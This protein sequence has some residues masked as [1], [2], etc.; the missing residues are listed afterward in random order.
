MGKKFAILIGPSG[1]G[2]NT[3]CRE[4]V[5]YSHSK[6]SFFKTIQ[7]TTRNMREEEKKQSNTIFNCQKSNYLFI[8]EP[9]YNLLQDNLVGTIKKDIYKFNGFYGT[10]PLFHHTSVNVII[11]AVE[12]LN[13]FLNTYKFDKDDLLR[14]FYINGL[15]SIERD[16]RDSSKENGEILDSLFSLKPNINDFRVI[17]LLSDSRTNAQ[18]IIR[19]FE[20]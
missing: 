9:T 18:N 14:I 10:I 13:D 3:I 17:P 4:L 16:D 15:H 8:D 1:S 19:E 7:L 20:K 2:K 6:L 11:L 5:N 12:G